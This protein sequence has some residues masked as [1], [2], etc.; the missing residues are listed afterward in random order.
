MGLGLAALFMLRNR[1]DTQAGPVPLPYQAPQLA[2]AAMMASGEGTAPDSPF[3]Q[4]SAP[5]NPVFFFNQGGE[6][7]RVPTSGIPMGATSDEDIGVYPGGNNRPELEFEVARSVPPSG[8]S[9][10]SPT[11]PE[12]AGSPAVSVTPSTVWDQQAQ[13]AEANFMPLLAIQDTAGGGI[14]I[15][16]SNVDISNLSSKEQFRAVN[17]DTGF[18]F[19]AESRDVLGE[20]VRGFTGSPPGPTTNAT[21]VS[22]TA[23]FDTSIPAWAGGNNWWDE[24]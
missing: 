19:T 16:G 18:A 1:D 15:L 2:G 14:D 20:Y 11:T 23:T 21:V 5:A 10:I 3:Q 6:M 7:A 12:F 17:V 24:G 22:Q 4:Y 8:T 9:D 13:I